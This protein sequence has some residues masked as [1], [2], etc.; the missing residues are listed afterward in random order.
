MQAKKKKINM[1]IP[2]YEMGPFQ[3]LRNSVRHCKKIEK[4]L[5]RF[6]RRNLGVKSVFKIHVSIIVSLNLPSAY[7]EYT[8]LCGSC[9]NP[10]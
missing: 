7:I 4:C 2:G 10:K 8:L 9:K 3:F 5:F 1:N 6:S